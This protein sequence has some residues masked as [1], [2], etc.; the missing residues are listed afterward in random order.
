MEFLTA[1]GGSSKLRQA[2]NK[3]LAVNALQ[4]LATNGIHSISAVLISKH[5][6]RNDFSE[7]KKKQ[8]KA[9]NYF[10]PTTG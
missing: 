8:K 1:V 10:R 5:G 6:A 7:L 9:R 3:Y 2:A 4:A